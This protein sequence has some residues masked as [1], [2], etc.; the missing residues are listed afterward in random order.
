MPVAQTLAAHIAHFPSADG[1]H[2][3]SSATGK[4]INRRNIYNRHFK[5]A[6]KRTALPARTRIHDLRHT[7]ASFLISS[8][9]RW[10]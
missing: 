2:V 6:V 10:R 1:S 8:V 3:F 4:A 9:S 5:P 7:C